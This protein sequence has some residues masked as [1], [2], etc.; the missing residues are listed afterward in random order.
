MRSN[1]IKL[2]EKQ[3]FWPITTD[4]GTFR[5]THCTSTNAG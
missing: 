1:S 3:Y 4:G 5:I 2:A